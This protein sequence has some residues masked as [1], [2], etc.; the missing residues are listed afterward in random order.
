MADQVWVLEDPAGAMLI[1]SDTVTQ[2]S[3]QL[4]KAEFGM[5]L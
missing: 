2:A 1:T 3:Q 5:L 4:G